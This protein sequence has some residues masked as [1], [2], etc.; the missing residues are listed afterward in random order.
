MV[1]KIE[2]RSKTIEEIRNNYLKLY[3][4]NDKQKVIDNSSM[5]SLGLGMYAER[6]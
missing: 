5:Q 2:R 4:E 1:T 3:F 6:R